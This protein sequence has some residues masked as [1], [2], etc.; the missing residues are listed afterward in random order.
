VLN[1]F[2]ASD[3]PAGW[4]SL[5][6]GNELAASI[7]LAAGRAKEDGRMDLVGLGA[8]GTKALGGKLA[9]DGTVTLY[10][11]ITAAWD[12]SWPGLPTTGSGSKQVI[13]EYTFNHDGP[14]ELAFR[15]AY[16][17]DLGNKLTETVARLD[18]RD[19]GNRAVAQTLIDTP[20]PWPPSVLGHLHE[21]MARIDT[22]GTV[23]TTVSEV[24][25]SSRGVSGH[26]SDEVAFGFAGTLIDVHKQLV[27]A[28]AR[29]NGSLARDRFDCLGDQS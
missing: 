25:D 5:E 11:R 16:P 13:V 18:L 24:K 3:F 28:Y 6:G 15:N 9:R 21:V 26:I 20:L 4:H 22:H 10:G 7:G 27:S 8:S 14:R 29:T 19:A 17:S 12:A 23:E 2:N 1:S